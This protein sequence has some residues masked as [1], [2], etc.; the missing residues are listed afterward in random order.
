MLKKQ[1]ILILNR[2][3]L[4]V[5][6]V[7][8]RGYGRSSGRPSEQGFYRDAQAVYN[9]LVSV[10]KVFPDDIILY[11]ESLGGAVAIDLAT[12][13][14]IKG[15]ITE[16]AFSS[17]Q[18]VARAVYPFLPSFFISSKFDSTKSNA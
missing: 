18:D 1:K 2:L 16:C 14:T 8:Y 7:D 4:D 6:I 9:F 17:T 11:G 15:L 3:G 10:R 5:F 12:K 13:K